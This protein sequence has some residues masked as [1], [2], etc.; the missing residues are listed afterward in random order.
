MGGTS[1]DVGLIVDGVPLRRHDVVF[2]KYHLLVSMADIRAI[3]A[4][5]GSIARVQGRYLRVGPESAG[6]S[7]G[8]VCY[9]QGGVEP[10]VTDADLVLGILDPSRF[11]GGR[12][13]LDLDAAQQA[14]ADHVAR[15]LG[16]SVPEA[17]AGIKQIVDARMADLLR[18][19]TIERGHDPR[20]FA[21]YAFGGA[22]PTHAPAFAL[23]LVNEIV[24]P[25]TQSVHSALGAIASDLAST[26]AISEPTRLDRSAADGN[27]E[28]VE[29]L[30][31]TLEAD[32]LETLVEPGAAAPSVQLERFVEM[33]FARQTK[34][35]RVPYPR[36]RPPSLAPLVAEFLR[37]YA[38]RY[39]EESLPETAGLELVTFAVE[40]RA[41]LPRPELRAYADA[42]PDASD[43][44]RGVRDVWDAASRAFVPTAVYEG[45]LLRPGNRIEGPAVIEYAGTTVALGGGQDAVV[46]R[47]LDLVIRRT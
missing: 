34:E 46:D 22:G 19:V 29:Q 28:R 4:G 17:A 43:A 27:V 2:E 1:T 37:S 20:A 6:A 25:A 31:A 3:G 13:E 18:T 41:E 5:G 15:P 42:G 8:P 21:L 30:F 16:L 47:L 14:I 32:A 33:R 36:E 10:T 38:L 26:H 23:E 24:V 11:L 7:P 39:G 40:A 45:E 12:L 35:L 9:A 44:A